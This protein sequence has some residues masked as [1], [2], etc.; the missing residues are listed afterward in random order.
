MGEDVEE[1]LRA[2]VEERDWA[3]FHSPENLAKSIA[4]EAAELL[5]CFQWSTDAQR[6]DVLA[7]LA[8][9]MTY[10]HLLARRLNADPDAIILEKLEVTRQKYPA[11]KTPGRAGEHGQ[12]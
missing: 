12:L 4:I 6:D 9:V 3:Q 8:D 5:E 2:F 7:E 1:S 11:T 10:C